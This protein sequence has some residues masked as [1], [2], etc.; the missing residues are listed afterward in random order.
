MPT[1]SDILCATHTPQEEPDTVNIV[2]FITELFCKVDDAIPD[3][4]L[5]HMENCG[6]QYDSVQRRLAS[7]EVEVEKTPP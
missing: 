5:S 3:A 2:N 4:G 6:V 7:S 1:T